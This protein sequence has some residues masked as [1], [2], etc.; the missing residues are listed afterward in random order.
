[1]CDDALQ[2]FFVLIKR[3]LLTSGTTGN[4][5]IVC[6][7][8][9]RLASLASLQ[10]QSSDSKHTIN[11]TLACSVVGMIFGKTLMAWAVL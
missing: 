3:N 6:S 9:Y 2:I 5:G 7:E 10:K 4:A 11:R 8:K 1:M